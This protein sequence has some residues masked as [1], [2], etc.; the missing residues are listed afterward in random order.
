M[1]K[2]N[3]TVKKGRGRPRRPP[4]TE[5]ARWIDAEKIDLEILAERANV[6]FSTICG[7]RRGDHNPSLETAADIITIARR[8]HDRKLTI[9]DFLPTS[10]KKRR[11]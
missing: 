1:T 2:A 9:F 8:F 3:E 4:L 7:I 5:F 10:A 11:G 6:S